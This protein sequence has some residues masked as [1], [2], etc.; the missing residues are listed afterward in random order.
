MVAAKYSLA[1][2]FLVLD[3]ALSS[4]DVASARGI[5][6][7]PAFPAFPEWLVFCLTIRKEIRINFICWMVGKQYSW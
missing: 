5:T 6:I 2:P 3:T 4:S 1:I 7:Y